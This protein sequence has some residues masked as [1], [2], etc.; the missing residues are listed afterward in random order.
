MY[1]IHPLVRDKY[2]TFNGTN[3]ANM[4][5]KKSPLPKEVHDEPKAR[6]QSGGARREAK[7]GDRRRRG[8]QRKARKKQRHGNKTDNDKPGGA[9][10]TR[11]GAAQERRRA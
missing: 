10:T 4:P 7:A 11:K 5:T 1:Y 2:D 8:K 3:A 6:Q 9:H